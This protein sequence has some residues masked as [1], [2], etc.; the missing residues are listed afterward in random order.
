MRVGEA[1]AL[2]RQPVHVRR[3]DPRGPVAA[4]IAVADVV[5]QNEDDIG[6]G[7]DF[8]TPACHRRQGRHPGHHLQEVAPAATTRMFGSFYTHEA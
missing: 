4:E 7:M 6:S 5:R 2:L 3:L 1:D 8:G